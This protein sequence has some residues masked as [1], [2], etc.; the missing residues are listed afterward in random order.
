MAR[1]VGSCCCCPVCRAP[2]RITDTTRFAL[3]LV[4][5][6]GGEN[7]AAIGGLAKEGE[8]GKPIRTKWSTWQLIAA[9]LSWTIAYQIAFTIRVK[10]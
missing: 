9:L 2:N 7:S 6:P 10:S 8:E 4:L 5:S 3:D 1:M